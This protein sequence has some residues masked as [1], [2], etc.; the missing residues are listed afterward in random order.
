M[1]IG[2]N[3][4]MRVMLQNLVSVFDLVL[5]NLRETGTIEGV[6]AGKAYSVPDERKTIAHVIANQQTAWRYQ[7]KSPEMKESI[8][9]LIV[10]CLSWLLKDQNITADDQTISGLQQFRDIIGEAV[11]PYKS[12]MAQYVVDNTKVEECITAMHNFIDH[13]KGKTVMKYVYAFIDCGIITK[14]MSSDLITEFGDGIGSSTIL[15]RY[16]MDDVYDDDDEQD[17]LVGEIRIY[18]K[19]HGI[20]LNLDPDVD[21][22]EDHDEEVMLTLDEIYN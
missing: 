20:E 1:I 8:N 7:S 9:R 11:S 19:E 22:D 2:H 17:R 16:K 4:F 3:Y 5:G 18:M 12:A 14:P 21:Q 13:K 10:K 15:N 6:Y